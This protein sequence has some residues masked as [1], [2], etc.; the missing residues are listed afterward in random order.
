M[1]GWIL[2]NLNAIK[3]ISIAGEV[4]HTKTD[5]TTID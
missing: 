1:D 3:C 2:L 5:I 4:T